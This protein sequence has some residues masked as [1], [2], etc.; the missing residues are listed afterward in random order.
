MIFS[1][2]TTQIIRWIVNTFFCFGYLYCVIEFISTNNYAMI[3]LM[4]PFIIVELL[5]AGLLMIN[6][7]PSYGANSINEIIIPVIAAMWP[8]IVA[9]IMQPHL[10]HGHPNILAIGVIGLIVVYI[11]EL[12]ALLSIRH[13]FS[14]LPEA[15]LIVNSGIYRYIRHPLYSLYIIWAGINL[16]ITWNVSYFFVGMLPLIV[17]LTI[18]ARIEERKLASALAGYKDYKENTGMFF[19]KISLASKVDPSINISEL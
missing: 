8:V 19:P 12:A 18:R 4:I 5:S 16:L 6:K 13:A 1:E 10:I 2:A 14:I 15:R 9:Q 11:L 7:R 3:I 17:F